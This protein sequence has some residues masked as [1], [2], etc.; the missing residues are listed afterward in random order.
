MSYNVVLQI[1][2]EFKLWDWTAKGEVVMLQFKGKNFTAI[3]NEKG[4]WEIKLPAQKAG[5]PCNITFNASN[6]VEVQNIL[7]GEIYF[8]VQDSL[9]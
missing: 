2:K 7:F 3:T 1:N 5:D 4:R 8:Y 9:I 6:K